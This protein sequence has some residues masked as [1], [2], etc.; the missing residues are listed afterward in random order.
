MLPAEFPE[1]VLTCD[2][3]IERELKDALTQHEYWLH[4]MRQD[5]RF[6]A[7]DKTDTAKAARLKSLVHLQVYIQSSVVADL[8]QI[9]QGMAPGL[10]DGI[11][12]EFDWRHESGESGE[13]IWEWA[14]DR[15]LDP[16]QIIEET[17][18]KIAQDKKAAT[19]C[20]DKS[21]AKGAKELRREKSAA[22]RETVNLDAA[23]HPALAALETD[24][25]T[26]LPHNMTSDAIVHYVA[27]HLY[28]DGYRKIEGTK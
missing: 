24:I 8:L 18:A 2:L 19:P 3:I 21:V 10:A 12:R 20:Q 22:Y 7:K 16:E 1:P 15:G 6:D 11:A 4:H 25:R 27:R 14:T 26:S 9:I 23:E 17:K 5:M 28:T 13:L